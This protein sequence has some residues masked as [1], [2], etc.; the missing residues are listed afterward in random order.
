[1]NTH[2]TSA[3][4]MK[5]P[6]PVASKQWLGIVLT[7]IIFAAAFRVFRAVLLPD[8]PN[9]SPVMAI[10]FCGAWFLPGTLA[11]ILPIF[12]LVI[13]D[14]VLNAQYAPL[15]PA[16]SDFVR[17]GCYV[18]AAVLGMLMRRNHV[19]MVGF[20]SGVLA[21]A[22]GFY[23]ITNSV[24]WF[25]STLYPQTF[26]GWIQALTVGLPGYAPTW[27]FFRNS[28]VSDLLFSGVMVAVAAWVRNRAQA[29]VFAN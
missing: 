2:D 24:A 23:L 11:L 10:A 4:R 18:A 1:M 14:I 20:W 25:G 29:Y 27:T 3:N 8:L 26:S 7:L 28:L 17:Y 19:G 12:A 15:A 13:S 9:F 6:W 22:A 21:S 16:L 5:N